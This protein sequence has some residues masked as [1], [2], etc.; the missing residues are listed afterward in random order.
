MVRLGVY[1]STYSSAESTNGKVQRGMSGSTVTL[2]KH[3]LDIKNPN[4][5]YGLVQVLIGSFL[6]FLLLTSAPALQKMAAA[7]PHQLELLQRPVSDPSTVGR[8][9]VPLIFW[10]ISFLAAFAAVLHVLFGVLGSLKNLMSFFVPGDV[11]KG[12]RDAQQTLSD[13]FEKQIL[14]TYQL[15]MGGLV[16]A[17]AL[18]SQRLRYLSTVQRR[19]AEG[20]GGLV[21][22][23]LFLTGLVTLPRFIPAEAV[24][25]AD[26]EAFVG[27]GWPLPYLLALVSVFA[28]T[29]KVL[30]TLAS[31][32]LH[33]PGVRFVEEQ[34]E[35]ETSGNPA[36]LFNHLR[37]VSN[38]LRVQDMPNR[39]L[40]SREP[41]MQTMGQHQTQGFSAELMFETQPIPVRG[42]IALNAIVMDL[43][44][45]ALRCAGYALLLQPAWVL[46]GQQ[47][48]PGVALVTVFSA[49]VALML[50]SGFLRTGY[51]LHN[52]FRFESDVFWVK[53]D[54]TCT[55]SKI[56]IGDG[57]GGQLH[58]ERVAMQ[59]TAYAHIFGARITTECDEVTVRENAPQGE[60]MEPNIPLVQ[61]RILV[62]S[63]VDDT[64][65]RRLE[66][67]MEGIKE[68]P[69][70]EDKLP[71]PA[72]DDANLQ[73][74]VRSNAQIAA[75]Q[76]QARKDP[77]AM[78]ASPSTKLLE[79]TRPP[80]LALIEASG[81]KTCP[82]CAE[83]VKV[84][85]RKCRFCGYVFPGDGAGAE[86]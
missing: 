75:L 47:L 13:F 54:G 3:Q 62:D 8:L 31:I 77:Q 27:P 73:N 12:I 76:T 6:A 51:S 80:S 55:A 42:G 45:G 39:L 33:V 15:P 1:V 5:V 82:D 79:G 35:V 49:F 40:R 37:K 18:I 38:E 65:R 78:L 41:S 28:V 67:L 32:P 7:V 57:H 44:G 25:E 64:F 63:R 24:A 26:L 56:G 85:A 84:A 72:M 59:L 68:S 30:A 70:T 19:A 43:G 50:G 61:P 10:G 14:R 60:V 29:I 16:T 2:R 23:L 69:A 58:A 86:Q 17:S 74:I 21:V 34:L 71:G 48:T 11:P 22:G 46:G 20:L 66:K 83:E 52:W 53:L 9:V 4:H 81:S 36:N